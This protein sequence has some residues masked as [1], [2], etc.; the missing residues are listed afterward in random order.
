M[1]SQ[2]KLLKDGNRE[3]S[4]GKRKSS[5]KAVPD[6]K[7]NEAKGRSHG[8]LGLC[9]H[10]RQ[11]SLCKEC[12]GSSICQQEQRRSRCKK[13]GRLSICQHQRIRR[14]SKECRADVDESIQ[15]GVK[16]P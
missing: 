13:C 7:G 3:G 6:N 9:E 10:Q 4:A 11:K 2:N 15:A 12:R 8:R 16:E 5:E 1:R 14:T